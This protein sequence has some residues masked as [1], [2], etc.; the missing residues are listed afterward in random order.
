[1]GT[2]KSPIRAPLSFDEALS[3]A[4]VLA[5][6]LLF[7]YMPDSSSGRISW[8]CLLIQWCIAIW[9]NLHWKF[10]VSHVFTYCMR[11]LLLKC[12]TNLRVWS[13][14]CFV[15]TVPLLQFWYSSRRDLFLVLLP[16]SRFLLFCKTTFFAGVLGYKQWKAFRSILCLCRVASSE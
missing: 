7:T 14:Q 1:M 4:I 2:W 15:Y 8:L 5:A 9:R 11:G 13:M 10:H 12:W 3:Q 6:A 16:S